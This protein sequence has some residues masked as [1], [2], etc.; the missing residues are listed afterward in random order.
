[1]A[2]GQYA[3]TGGYSA[4]FDELNNI[5]PPQIYQSLPAYIGTVPIAGNRDK[6]IWMRKES[7]QSVLMKCIAWEEDSVAS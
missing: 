2:C 7:R 4:I 1:M 5:Y 6:Q 3:G